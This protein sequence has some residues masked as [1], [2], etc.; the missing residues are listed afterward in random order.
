MNRR[1]VGLFFA[2]LGVLFAM[3]CQKAPELPEVEN[4]EGLIEKAKADFL[5]HVCTTD[6]DMSRS[7]SGQFYG[8]AIMKG[9]LLHHVKLAPGATWVVEVDFIGTDSE[10]EEQTNGTAILLY[11][12]DKDE[13]IEEEIVPTDVLIGTSEEQIEKNRK[14]AKFA[15]DT[16]RRLLKVFGR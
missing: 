13:G 5:Y 12:S 9:E 8:C 14:I 16:T 10:T 6:S 11:V 15:V 2:V 7:Y 3:S 1:H 4:K